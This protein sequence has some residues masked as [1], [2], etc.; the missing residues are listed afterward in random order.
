MTVVEVVVVVMEMVVMLIGGLCEFIHNVC[1]WVPMHCIPLHLSDSF[2][3][4]VC[5]YV[6][7]HVQHSQTCLFSE[8]HRFPQFMSQSTSLFHV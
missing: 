4:I 6:S 3:Y 8:Y 5:V 7:V 2:L 1:I